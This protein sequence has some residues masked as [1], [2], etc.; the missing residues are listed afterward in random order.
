MHSGAYCKKSQVR[1]EG[2]FHIYVR[3]GGQ[4][5]KLRFHFCPTCGSTVCWEADHSPDH[6]GI[7]V[8]CFADPN[9]PAPTVSG[10]EESMADWMLLP[11]TVQEHSQQR[12]LSA[13]NRSKSMTGRH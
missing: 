9:F 5:R 3:E 6:V 12:P 8:G 2:P 4:G 13:V 11:A 7:A 10:W 1:T